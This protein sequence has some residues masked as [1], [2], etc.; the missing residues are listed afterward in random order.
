MTMISLEVTVWPHKSKT[1]QAVWPRRER[2][3]LHSARNVRIKV[4]IKT[5]RNKSEHSVMNNNDGPMQR[6]QNVNMRKNV[7][8]SAAC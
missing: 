8:L 6:V 7:R 3:T 5:S 2:I 4:Q 1:T